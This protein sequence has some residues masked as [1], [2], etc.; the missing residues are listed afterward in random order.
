M[1]VSTSRISRIWSVTR[2]SEGHV[3]K[4][5]DRLGAIG[6]DQDVL[7]GQ[8]RQRPHGV[9]P[10]ATGPRTRPARHELASDVGDAQSLTRLRAWSPGPRAERIE[11][12]ENQRRGDLER[13]V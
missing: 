5:R 3:E 7:A 10:D 11:R 9:D 2:R 13:T 4:P 12:I 1:P 6:E 8:R